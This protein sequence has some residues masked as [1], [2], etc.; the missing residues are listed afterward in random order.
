MG[1]NVEIKLSTSAALAETPWDEVQRV[2]DPIVEALLAAATN[3]RIVV[4]SFDPDVMS[5]FQL[6]QSLL[7]PVYSDISCWFLSAGKKEDLRQDPRRQSLP[8]AIEFAAKGGFA[9]VVLDSSE[10]QCDPE[11]AQAAVRSGLQVMSYGLAN[12]DIMWVHRQRELGVAGVIV[13]DVPTIVDAASTTKGTS[14]SFST[15]ASPRSD[16]DTVDVPRLVS[17]R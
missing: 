4:S 11:S 2:V 17:F 3:H 12:N 5:Y 1:L 7:S 9:G 15:D 10:L 6:Q 13:D 8:A 14:E 16:F